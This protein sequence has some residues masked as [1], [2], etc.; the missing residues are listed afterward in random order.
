MAIIQPPALATVILNIC[1][2]VVKYW[3]QKCVRPIRSNSYLIIHVTKMFD[4]WKGPTYSYVSL[5]TL[6]PNSRD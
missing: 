6:V 3:V 4:I 1:T 2:Y 5:S